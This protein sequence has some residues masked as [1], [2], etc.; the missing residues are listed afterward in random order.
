MK[1]VDLFDPIRRWLDGQGYR[2]SSEVKDCDIVATL[3]DDPETLIVIELKTRMSLA[4]INQGVARKELTESV[5]IAVPVSGAKGTLRNARKTLATLRRLELGLLFV[6]LLRDGT[7]VEP[8]L[9]PRPFTPRKRR[10]RRSAILREVDHRYAELDT[11]GQPRSGVR[12]TAY[13]QR[14]LRIAAI[15]GEEAPLSPKAIVERGGPTEAG[16]IVAGNHYGWFDRVARGSYALSEA[17]NAAL[18]IHSDAI[19][20]VSSKK[21]SPGW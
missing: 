19:A 6:R 17:G 3:P 11:G 10:K 14:A 12:Y 20:R 18:S 13:R 1:E 2:V 16:R 9:H 4:L 21:D 8:V 15:L 7:R 5:Y